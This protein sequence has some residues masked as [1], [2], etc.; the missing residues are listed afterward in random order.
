MALGDSITSGVGLAD[1][2]YNIAQIGYDLQPN[3]EG[4]PS[5]CYTAL[6]GKGLGWTASTR[7]IWACPA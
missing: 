3:F 7:S 4:Y 1:M 2:K 5:Q 6:V